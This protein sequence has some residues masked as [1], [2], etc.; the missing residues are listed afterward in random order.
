MGAT[1][2]EAFVISRVFDAPRD[3]VWKSRTEP[4]RLKTRTWQNPEQAP[5]PYHNM[6]PSIPCRRIP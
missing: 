2:T 1:K 6:S 4:E 3:V 5:P